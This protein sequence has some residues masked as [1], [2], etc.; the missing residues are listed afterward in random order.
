MEKAREIFQLKIV[1]NDIKPM[2]WRRFVVDADIKLPDLHKVIQTTMGWTNS[3]LH[4]FVIN[5]N[6]YCAPDEEALSEHIDYRRVQ[7]NQMINKKGA[8]FAYEYD[9]GDGWEH[10]ITLERI[11]SRE[12][13]QYYPI[14][15][16]GERSCPP[17][18]CGSSVG[19]EH[20]LEVL[21]NP[22]HEEYNELKEW[23]GEYFEPESFDIKAVN[24]LLRTRDYGVVTFL[25]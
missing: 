20:L 24:E 5:D 10:I 19:Y 11:L 22:G 14:C 13:N 1:L 9:F 12:K 16:D 21:S 3:H 7:L 23:V 17:E 15:V 4:Q 18:D 6:Y 2:I 25:D 8:K